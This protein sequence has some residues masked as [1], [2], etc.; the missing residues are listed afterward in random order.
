V[1]VLEHLLD[2]STNPV[3]R[4]FPWYLRQGGAPRLPKTN[5]KDGSGGD[6]VL[7]GAF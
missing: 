3:P 6:L 7:A 1:E 4:Y 5:A 2:L